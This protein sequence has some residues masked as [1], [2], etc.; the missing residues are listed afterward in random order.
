MTEGRFAIKA[1]NL[2]TSLQA[3]LPLASR[4][5]NRADLMQ[6]RFQVGLHTIE[7]H[8]T[9]GRALG[10]VLAPLEE[11]AP[12]TFCMQ[13]SYVP[14]LIKAVRRI[15]TKERETVTVSFSVTRHR[16]TAR[17]GDTQLTLPNV[18]EQLAFPAVERV[19]PSDVRESLTAVTTFG[20][21]PGLLARVMRAADHISSS[22]IWRSPAS[23]KHAIR[24]DVVG[25]GGELAATY[26]V[27]PMDIG[28]V[29]LEDGDAESDTQ[30]TIAGTESEAEI[31]SK[32]QEKT[33]PAKRGSKGRK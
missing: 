20:V 30:T 24:F 9:D 21:S 33:R 17:I 32:A 15:G 5:K 27:M 4:D 19:I 23:P 11:G 10:R 22:V 18:A 26:V 12:I 7:F 13:V 29:V 16:V 31:E 8:A 2:L 14:T 28:G 1:D 6:I 3:I 25:G